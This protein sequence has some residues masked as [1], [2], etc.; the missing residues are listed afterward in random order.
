MNAWPAGGDGAGIG[1]MDVWLKAN[2][3]ALSARSKD[4]EEFAG[5]CPV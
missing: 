5:N 3:E 2:L 4:L 1:L